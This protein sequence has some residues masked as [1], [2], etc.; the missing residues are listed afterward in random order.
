ML[1]GKA[2]VAFSN[3]F[4]AIQKCTMNSKIRIILQ[5]PKSNVT[6]SGKTKPNSRWSIQKFKTRFRIH[7][8]AFACVHTSSKA[9]RCKSKTVHFT[10]RPFWFENAKADR[11]ASFSVIAMWMQAISEVKMKKKLNDNGVLFTGI[12]TTLRL[13]L[14]AIGF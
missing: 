8:T 9:K 1:L 3:I 11:S 4:L 12:L 5:C 14:T 2:Y 7:L 6:W 13:L 10:S